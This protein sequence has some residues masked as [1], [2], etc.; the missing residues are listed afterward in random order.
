MGSPDGSK[1]L[2]KRRMALCAIP[3]VASLLAVACAVIGDLES[4]KAEARRIHEVQA[5]MAAVQFVR[6][7]ITDRKPDRKWVTRVESLASPVREERQREAVSDLVYFARGYAALRRGDFAGAKTAFR[8]AAAVYDLSSEGMRYMLAYYAYAAANSGDT[9]AVEML[10]G[11]MTPEEQGFDYQLAKAVVASLAYRHEEAVHAIELALQWRP[12]TDG[13]PLQ[14]AHQYAEIVEWI[15]ESTR[16]AKYRD[17]MLAWAHANQDSPWAWP[18]AI[19][20]KH[21]R[22]PVERRRAA[23]AALYLDPN[24]ERLSSLDQK[25]LDG[26]VRDFSQANPLL[27]SREELI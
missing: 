21:S 24:S 26:A 20:A 15:Y 5:R 16:N 8:D 7:G 27:G 17:A 18:H 14:S 11:R 4:R 25:D 6:A 3:L 10:L 19:I 23:I 9:S 2:R 13:R 22:D 1:D 12:I